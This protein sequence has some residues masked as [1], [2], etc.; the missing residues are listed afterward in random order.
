LSVDPEELT[1]AV[2]DTE[3]I[4]ATVSPANATNKDVTW[5]SSDD[6][7]ATVA[8]GVVTAVAKGTATITVTTVD[9]GFKT[10][11]VTVTVVPEGTVAMIGTRHHTIAYKQQ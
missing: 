4:T 9:G 11:T 10:D 8:D 7:V 5:E 6:T 1:L 2:G 3:T